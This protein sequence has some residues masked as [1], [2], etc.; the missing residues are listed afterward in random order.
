MEELLQFVYLMPV[1]VIRFRNDGSVDMMNPI[2]A[3]CL[4][5]VTSAD[6]LQNIYAP[7]APFAPELHRLVAQFEGPSG[8]IFEEQRLRVQAGGNPM[9]LSLTVQKI[10]DDVH[11]AVLNDVTKLAEQEDKLYMDRQKF[12]AIFDHVR[13]YAIFTLT[14]DGLIDEWNH[15]MERYAGWLADEVQGSSMSLCF[16]ED[17]PDRPKLDRLLAE[18][19]RIGSV[20]TEGWQRR[21]DGSRL[22]ANSVI[23]ALPD[24]TG[25]IRGFVVV[26][27]DMTER[28]QFEDSMKQLAMVDPLTGAFNRRRGDALLAIEF[29]RHLRFGRPFAVLMIDVDHFKAINDNFGHQVGDDVL[30]ALVQ[31]C[32]NALRAIDMVARW[33]GEEFLV[34]LPE[35]DS[36]AAISIAERLR[37]V[38]EASEI[39]HATG[40]NTRITISIVAAVAADDSIKELLRRSDLALYE[41]KASGRNRVVLWPKPHPA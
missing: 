26:S 12:F 28:K 2:A 23:T 21:R 7:L 5:S 29:G 25:T 16:P 38:V 37:G 39:S 17:D 13:D 1:G 18:A 30:C 9:V 41:A 40:E 8:V 14:L 33:G 27:R 36:A 4:L 34:V 10:K 19:R 32:K 3:A 35:T 6:T 15:S 20:E 31:T 22:W 11:M 24:A